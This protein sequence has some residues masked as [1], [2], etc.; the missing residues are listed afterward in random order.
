MV[1]VGRI[2]NRRS[3]A[4]ADCLNPKGDWPSVGVPLE[5]LI[6]FIERT[7]P[8]APTRKE[9]GPLSEATYG[10]LKKVVPEHLQD[11]TERFLSSSF[12]TQLPF[13]DILLDALLSRTICVS[14]ARDPQE[15][16]RAW[17][18][19]VIRTHSGRALLLDSQEPTSRRMGSETAQANG[20]VA[21]PILWKDIQKKLLAICDAGKPFT[22]L[23]I[24]AKRLGCS[25][26]TVRK[27]V[28]DSK[29]L[30]HW[31]TSGED[32]GRRAVRESNTNEVVIDRTMQTCEADPADT[33]ID[34]LT[35]DETAEKIRRLTDEQRKDDTDKI[36]PR[37]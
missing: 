20:E 18:G 33:A 29:S 10:E 6:G 11:A 2:P 28:Q 24:L 12:P 4:E 31:S 7:F 36:I 9:Y 30:N 5:D 13:W 26:G 1:R 27:A 35:E 25:P 15:N 8:N 32:R 37:V 17:W 16:M 14:N 19:P 3:R 21:N 34:N 22:S 23:R